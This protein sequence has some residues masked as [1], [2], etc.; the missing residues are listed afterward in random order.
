MRVKRAPLSDLM[1]PGYP[2]VARCLSR[3]G[4][5]VLA[6]AVRMIFTKGNL[7]YSSTSTMSFSSD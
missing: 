6:D 3:T 7:E 1:T 2:N 5:T 4:I